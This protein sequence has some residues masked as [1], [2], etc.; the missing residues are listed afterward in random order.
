MKPGD[1]V[2][3]TGQFLRNTGQVVGGEAFRQWTVVECECPICEDGTCV[4]LDEPSHY[5]PDRPRHVLKVNLMLA[6]K[7]DY[8]NL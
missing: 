5:D 8:T 1:K 6:N 3:L 4:A 2:K 7:P